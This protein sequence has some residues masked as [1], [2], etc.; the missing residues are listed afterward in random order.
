M[1]I[2][3]VRRQVGKLNVSK[4]D[5]AAAGFLTETNSKLV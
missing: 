3:F 4:N 5:I 2:E 1:I